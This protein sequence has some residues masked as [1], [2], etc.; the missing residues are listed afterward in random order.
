[1]VDTRATEMT[2][3]T[4]VKRKRYQFETFCYGPKNCSFYKAGA[5][6]KVRGRSGMTWEEEDWVDDDATA[7]RGLDE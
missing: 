5:T 7:H 6:H 2:N 1:M 4:K 3:I